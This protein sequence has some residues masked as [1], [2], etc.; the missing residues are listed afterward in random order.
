MLRRWPELFGA[1]VAGILPNLEG[2]GTRANLERA[3][4][5]TIPVAREMVLVRDVMSQKDTS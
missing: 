1:V 3:Y 2:S 5:G 4:K